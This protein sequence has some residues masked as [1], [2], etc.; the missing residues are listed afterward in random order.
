MA[1]NIFESTVKARP[2]NV[3]L[4]IAFWHCFS[5]ATILAANFGC[6]QFK[7]VQEIVSKLL[8]EA[9]SVVVLLGWNLPF[10][11]KQFILVQICCSA[12]N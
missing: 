7:F 2:V 9:S 11:D 1:Q 3:G 12:H 8:R 10:F 4:Y 6:I 5:F